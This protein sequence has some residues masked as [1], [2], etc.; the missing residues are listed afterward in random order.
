MPLAMEMVRNAIEAEPDNVELHQRL[1]EYAFRSNDQDILVSAYLELASCLARTGAP[2]KA[3]AVFQ[4]VLSLSPGNEEATTAIQALDGTPEAGTP[5]S[6]AS[7]EEYVDLGA[8]ILGEEA[9]ETTRWTVA[10]EAPTGDDEAD[11]AKMLGQFKEKV[12]EH[13]SA[14]DVGAHHDLGTAYME[15]G[16]LDEAI[17]EFQMALRASPNHLPTHEIMGR[18]WMAKGNPDMAVR[19]LNRALETTYEVEDEMIGIYYLM[20][21]AQEALGNRGE[22]V[23]FYEKVFSLDINFEDVT[24]RLRALR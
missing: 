10:A 23:E 1:V 2:V 3:R 20:G 4:Q 13:L 14:D 16:L 22:A 21:Q 6:V 15:M 7:S 12:S 9:E 24:E 5:A 17:G 11:F 18:C 8:M 19:A